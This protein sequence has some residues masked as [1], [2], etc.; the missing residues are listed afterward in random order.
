MDSPETGVEI[1]AGDIAKGGVVGDVSFAFGM[2]QIYTAHASSSTGPA[3]S[4]LPCASLWHLSLSL[5]HTHIYT[6]IY[7]HIHTCTHMY[8]HIHTYTHT[9]AHTRTHA[10][11]HT[12]T[13]RSLQATPA[14]FFGCAS[15]PG[16]PGGGAACVNS[17]VFSATPDAA[18]CTVRQ[19]CGPQGLQ[20]P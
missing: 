12:H 4:L 17:S 11:T 20:G 9:Y 10:H 6:H 13:P 5:T 7:T 14:V 16:T 3:P 15:V 2:K 1:P 19:V 8:T 18:A